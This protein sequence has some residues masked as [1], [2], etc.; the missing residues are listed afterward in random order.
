MADHRVR[1]LPARPRDLPII[2]ADSRGLNVGNDHFLGDEL[3]NVP[4]CEER[5]L[6]QV[7][8]DIAASGIAEEGE[9]D[10]EGEPE[11]LLDVSDL[12]PSQSAEEALSDGAVPGLAEMA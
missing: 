8:T 4:I 2:T 6:P 3:V 11:S 1:R 12:A 10:P 5:Y 9:S 7:H